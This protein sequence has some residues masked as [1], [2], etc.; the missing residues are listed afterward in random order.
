ME[1]SRSVD[2]G[3][4]THSFIFSNLYLLFSVTF[5][6]ECRQQD[7]VPAAAPV[8][9]SHKDRSCVLITLQCCSILNLTGVTTSVSQ[10]LLDTLPAL[11]T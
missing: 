1:F 3:W 7:S 2:L 10:W 5:S 11:A 4:K 6:D 9:L 8:A